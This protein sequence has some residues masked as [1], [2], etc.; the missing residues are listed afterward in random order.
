MTLATLLLP[1]AFVLPSM[2]RPSP[3]PARTSSAV[4]MCAW[5]SRDEVSAPR[6]PH[7]QP[8]FRA[9][10][11]RLVT[12]DLVASRAR[13]GLSSERDQGRGRQTRRSAARPLRPQGWMGKRPS[14]LMSCPWPSHVSRLP[15]RGPTDA[16]TTVSRWP[17]R[18]LQVLIFNQGQQD[19]GV[20]TLQGGMARA[21][22]YVL[23]FEAGE[24]AGRF[25]QMLQGQGLE[26]ATP[27]RWGVDELHDF[28][29]ARRFAVSV[30][31]K[32][33]LIAPPKKNEFD[34]DAFNRV[35]G[36][37]GDRF[38]ASQDSFSQPDKFS[39]ERSAL[40]HM[41]EGEANCGDDDCLL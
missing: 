40:E 22:P 28:C 5:D 23:A 21:D 36:G 3:A 2:L 30:V 17:T 41:L 31:R 7:H 4:S 19:E 9:C 35:N 34:V 16:P 27:L 6:R 24:D 13:A 20:Y 39:H 11:V 8:H 12:M 10:H 15:A 1:L 37:M 18:C 25:A 33:C 29:V 26:G 32:D 14:G 38:G